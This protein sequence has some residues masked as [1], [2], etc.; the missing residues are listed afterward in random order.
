MTVSTPSSTIT[1]LQKT[2]RTH[3][4]RFVLPVVVLISVSSLYFRAL[5]PWVTNFEDFGAHAKF[6]S[7]MMQTHSLNLPH[8]LYHL[9]CIAIHKALP[10]LSLDFIVGHLFPFICE[11]AYELSLFSV[12]VLMTSRGAST[13]RLLG[14]SILAFA[15]SIFG[16]INFLVDNQLFFGY[17]PVNVFHNP[18]VL[19]GKPL[20]IW[21][22]YLV[23]SMLKSCRVKRSTVI[24]TAAI[25]LLAILAK[26]NFVMVAVP[27]IAILAALYL[28]IGR[29]ERSRSLALGALLP[30][31]ALLA[32]Q[33]YYSY[34]TNLMH[35]DRSH[36]ILAPFGPMSMLSSHLLEKLCLSVLCPVVVYGIF[37]KQ[38]VNDAPLNFSWA[39]ML[40]SLFCTYF[41][42][43]SGSRYGHLNFLWCAEMS[44]LMVCLTS[45]I[46]ICNLWL[47]PPTKFSRR[48]LRWKTALVIAVLIPHLAGGVLLNMTS[49]NYLET[50]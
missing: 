37:F 38:A 50:T 3:W 4:Q 40:V 29:K 5:P 6:A 11:F 8:S 43:E 47:H 27:V 30:S 25:T 19:L 23:A 17:I 32:V 26:P 35:L 18:T 15:I 13:A 14:Y 1:S 20:A 44:L 28:A 31:I 24:T 48:E 10:H 22:F 39:V 42:A 33:Y 16:P 21:F 34:N 45:A 36:I 2:E 9:C 49:H 46:F 7:E 12:I 41:L